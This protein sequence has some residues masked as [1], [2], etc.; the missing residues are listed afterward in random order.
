MNTAQDIVI[1]V[2]G[3][4]KFDDLEALGPDILRAIRI[5]VN[6][7][8]DHIRTRAARNVLS[9]VNLP[10]S[11]V[12]PSQGRLSVVKRASGTNLE[13]VIRAKGRATSLARFAATTNVKASRKNGVMV[14]VKTGRSQSLKRAFLI[15]LRAGSGVTDTKANLGLAIRLKP[16]ETITHRRLKLRQLFPNV[17]LL[18]GPS[19]YQLVA[20]TAED[21]LVPDGADYFEQEF[22]RQLGLLS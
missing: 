7:T 22:N 13:G 4:E 17:Y 12:S 2:E 18:M 1:A 15:P 5:S 9:Q 16:G 20:N 21:D 3:V 6:A 11:Y 19:V 8:L 14:R 10:A